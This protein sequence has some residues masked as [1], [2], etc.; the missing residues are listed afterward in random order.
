MNT[1]TEV[2]AEAFERGSSGYLLKTCAAT[3]MVVVVREVLRGKTYMSQGISRDAVD[4]LR[5]QH[6]NLVKEEERSPAGSVRCCNCWP[7]EE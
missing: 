3:E 1:D 4:S 7:K 6:K 5:W 2:A